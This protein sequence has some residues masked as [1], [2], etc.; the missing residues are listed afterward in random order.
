MKRLA[1]LLAS[2]ALLLSATVAFAANPKSPADYNG[3]NKGKSEVNHLYLYEKDQTSWDV[4]EDGAWGKLTYKTD[5]FVFNGHKLL[6]ETDYAL[7]RYLDPWPG[8]VTCLGSGMSDKDGNVHIA[9]D[10]KDGG[11]KVWLVLSADVDCGSGKLTGWHGSE[12]LFEY[13]TIDWL[14]FVKFIQ[15][16]TTNYDSYWVTI[17]GVQH[18]YRADGYFQF[19]DPTDFVSCDAGYTQSFN[20]VFNQAGYQDLEGDSGNLTDYLTPGESYHVCKY[21]AVTVW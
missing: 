12:Y 2:G 4:V 15:G 3:L 14:T 5:D 16:G 21:S 19:Y 10:W 7:V 9:G 20:W 11:P 6:P 18:E 13:N 17:N 8:K 1:T